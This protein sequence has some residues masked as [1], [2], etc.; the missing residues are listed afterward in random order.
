MYL[1]PPMEDEPPPGYVA[2]VA[3]HLGDLRRETARLVGG[4]LDA[5]H[6]YLDVL[7][8]VAGHWRRLRWWGRVRGNPHAVREYMLHRLAVRT[9]DWRDD[10]M[11]EVDVRILSPSPWAS[12]AAAL[13]QRDAGSIAYRKAAMVP[14]TH[15]SGV[16][17][18][19]DAGIA[20][21]QA[22]RRQQW[23]RAGRLNVGG[24]LLIG[25]MIQYMSALSAGQ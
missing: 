16:E 13:Y 19:A 6:L 8:D 14:D 18:V 17:A 24:I 21:V 12:S 3:A 7:A 1:I 25:G 9:K 10:Q 11:Y 15:R 2:F 4:D 22:Y 20:W 5:A 23:H